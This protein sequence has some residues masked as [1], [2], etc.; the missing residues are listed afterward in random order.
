M[1][2]GRKGKKIPGNTEVK[3]IPRN[4]WYLLYETAVCQAEG[5]WKRIQLEHEGG[6][7]Q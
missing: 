1:N 4:A 5:K 6:S 7:W 2:L 3:Q